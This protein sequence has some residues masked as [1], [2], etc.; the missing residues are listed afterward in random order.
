MGCALGAGT[1]A[2]AGYSLT[3]KTA[4]DLNATARR[5]IV[6]E[7]VQKAKDYCDQKET[8]TIQK[9]KDYCD[10]SLAKKK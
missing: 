2:T 1:A 10:Q 6:D 4:D 8:E 3:A 7:A 5:S 9:A